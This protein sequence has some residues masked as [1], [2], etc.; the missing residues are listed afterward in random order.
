M[1]F[2]TVFACEHCSDKH[3]GVVFAPLPQ[4]ITVN[5]NPVTHRGLCPTTLRDLYVARKP[6]VGGTKS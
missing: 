1:I 2:R 3:R 4:P 5:G 6:R